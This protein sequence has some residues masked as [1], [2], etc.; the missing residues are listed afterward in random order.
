MDE[1]ERKVLDALDALAIPYVL[2][3]HPPV[4]TVEQAREHWGVLRGAPCKNLFLR[5]YKGNRH[6]L[7]IAEATRPVDLKALTRALGEDRLSFGSAERLAVR[8]GVEPGAV[9]PFG[10]INDAAKSVIVVVDAGLKGFAALN[11]HPNVNTAS[12]EVSEADFE[13]FL[14]WTGHKVVWLDPARFAP[15]PLE[16]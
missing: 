1:R 12:V 9:S 13:R 2:H 3:D 4:F 14:A 16:A 15:P 11:F 10:L 8:L 5:N 6:Y 7:V